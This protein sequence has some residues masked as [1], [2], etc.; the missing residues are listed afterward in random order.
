MRWRSRQFARRVPACQW[1]RQ[2][3]RAKTALHF[4]VWTPA[5]DGARRPV[6]FWIH[7]GGFVGG[8]S[9]ILLYHGDTFAAKDVVL[10]STN[11]RVHAMGF[12]TL[13]AA[14]MALRTPRTVVSWT[15][16]PRLSG[17]APISPSLAATPTM[18]RSSA[19]Q[20]VPPVGALWPRRGRTACSTRPSGSPAQATTPARERLRRATDFFFNDVGVAHG[21]VAALQALPIEK[22]LS[23]V[24]NYGTGQNNAL[25]AVFGDDD[26]QRHAFPDDAR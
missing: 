25:Q 11:Y 15:S 17:C 6:L 16:S 4:N 14:A 9:S 7:G 24:A 3:P 23:R 12:R 20:P 21:D 19:S 2:S 22:I 10:V 13:K 8:S 18:S 1:A 5:T 26:S